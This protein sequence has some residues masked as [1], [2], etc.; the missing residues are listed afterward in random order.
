MLLL[1]VLVLRVVDNLYCYFRRQLSRESLLR[2]LS[3][4][5][6]GSKDSLDRWVEAGVRS[7][8]M[9]RKLETEDPSLM[10]PAADSKPTGKGLPPPANTRDMMMGNNITRERGDCAAAGYPSPN[11]KPGGVRKQHSQSTA[12][13]PENNNR[14]PIKNGF[15]PVNNTGSNSR[16]DVLRRQKEKCYRELEEQ[17]RYPGL[18]KD[19]ARLVLHS[20]N[21]NLN[22]HIY[23]EPS[24]ERCSP[25]PLQPS[26]KSKKFSFAFWK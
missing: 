18:D 17:E 24:F 8:S 2:S 4:S 13:I 26:T 20:S 10:N 14:Q 5:K 16:S 7:R 1:H 15:Y 21:L 23:S 3:R 12:I 9:W 6:T 22:Q 25:Q 11:L 19:T